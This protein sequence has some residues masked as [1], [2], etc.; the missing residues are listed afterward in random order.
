[1][2]IRLLDQAD[3]AELN[4]FLLDHCN[5]SMFLR[6]NL[7]RAGIEYRAQ[8]F[9]AQYVGALEGRRLIA[10]VAHGWSGHLLLQAPMYIEELVRHA[11]RFTSRSVADLIGPHDQVV[12]ARVALGM[13]DAN[14]RLDEREALMALDLSRLTVPEALKSGRVI[15]PTAYC[16]LT[17][18]WLP[19]QIWVSKKWF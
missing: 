14:T 9:Q 13:Q 1:M 16:R 17:C 3:L 10:V 19:A 6:S 4:S 5:G 2:R 11:V 7:R 18:S 8:Q 15:N 12:S